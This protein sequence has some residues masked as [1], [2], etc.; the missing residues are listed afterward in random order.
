MMQDAVLL[1]WR[2]VRENARLSV[3][4]ASPNVDY[5]SK[6]SQWLDRFGLSGDENKSPAELSGGMRQRVALIRTLLPE[7]KALLL[8]EPFTSLDFEM[9]LGVQRGLLAYHQ[10]HRSA[11]LLVT[12]DIEDAIALADKVIVLGGH[13]ATV[14]AE[15][16]ID[17]G[18]AEKDPVEARKS[19]RFPEY[20]ARIWQALQE[21]RQP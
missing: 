18:L 21:A 5:E 14:R 8:D 6:L 10:E 2:N 20:F 3:E 9:K 1:A 19:P 11:V 12:H 16:D 4:L 15:L 17:L 7:P 13:P